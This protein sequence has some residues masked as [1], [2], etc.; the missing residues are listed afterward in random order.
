[1]DLSSNNPKIRNKKSFQDALKEIADL[2]FKIV[3]CTPERIAQID[4]KDKS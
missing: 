3:F 4:K 2:K 1:M